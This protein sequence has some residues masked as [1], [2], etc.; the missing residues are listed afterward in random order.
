MIRLKIAEIDVIGDKI[1]EE[2]DTV[3]LK[4]SED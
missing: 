1:K 4:A 3:Y 2:V